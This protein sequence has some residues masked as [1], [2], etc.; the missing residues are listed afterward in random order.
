LLLGNCQLH[1]A[2]QAPTFMGHQVKPGTAPMPPCWRPLPSQ[3][4]LSFAMPQVGQDAG[5]G[6]GVSAEAALTRQLLRA[7]KG[8][9]AKEKTAAMKALCRGSRRLLETLPYS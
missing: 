5:A 4:I 8:R 7:D 9:I 3:V 2:R 6:C 1:V